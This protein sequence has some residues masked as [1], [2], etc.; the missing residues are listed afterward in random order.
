[1]SN[2]KQYIETLVILFEKRAVLDEAREM[3]RKANRDFI[4]ACIDLK[5][6]RAIIAASSDDI[7]STIIKALQKHAQREKKKEA[8]H[9]QHQD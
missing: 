1:M 5:P 7:K 3:E 8:E 2:Y 4:R 6:P 9:E